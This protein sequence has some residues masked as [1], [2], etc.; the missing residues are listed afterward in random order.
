MQLRSGKNHS[1]TAV[2]HESRHN[3]LGNTSLKSK[4]A[5]LVYNFLVSLWQYKQFF[6]VKAQKIFLLPQHHLLQSRRITHEL[7]HNVL[8]MFL[9][10]GS[11]SDEW[12]IYASFISPSVA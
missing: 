1:F 5:V 6:S 12:K 10:V 8:A 3:L 7:L 9:K 4:K 2:Q 11:R